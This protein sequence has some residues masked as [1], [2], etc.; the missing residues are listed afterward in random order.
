MVYIYIGFEKS[1]KTY[2]TYSF[3]I[4]AKIISQALQVIYNLSLASVFLYIYIYI[5]IYMKLLLT[6]F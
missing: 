1:I 6:V 3:N 5:Y 4:N 2:L